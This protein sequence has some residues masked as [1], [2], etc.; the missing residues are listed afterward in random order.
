MITFKEYITEGVTLGSSELRKPNSAT[1]QPRTDILRDLINARTPLETKDGK[2]VLVTDI[3]SAMKA[4]DQFEVDNKNFNLH[5]DRGLIKNTQLKKSKAFGGGGA[6]AGGGTDQTRVT[7]SAQCLWCAALLELGPTTPME[8][9]TEEHL[10]SAQRFI[11]VDAKFDEMMNISDAWK[12]SSYLSAQKLIQEGYIKRGM[13]FHRNDRVMK[14]I[15]A[16]KD[17][18]Y[19]N[20]D[21][22]KMSDDKWNPG[23]IWALDPS[24]DVS[25][26]DTTSIRGLQKSI[27][28][29]FVNRT[30]VAISLKLV[31]KT[32]KIKYYN[33][34]LP[35]DTD[36]HKITSIGGKSMSTGRGTFWSAKG[37]EIIVDGSTKIIV[38]DN[39]S[40]GTIKAEI[41]GKTARGGGAA[42]GYL[43]TALRQ[44]FGTRLPSVRDIS[45]VA[46][47]AHAGNE[48]DLKKIYDVFSKV[49]RMTYEEFMEQ[50]SSSN[51][52]ATWLHAKYGV[53]LFLEPLMS[54]GGSKAD[55][56]ITK[57]VNYAASSSED[58]SAFIKVYT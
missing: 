58:S 10:K 23:D 53:C 42:W 43:A 57:I 24:V 52:D 18:A 13:H 55:R 19:K 2:H 20:T 54:N 15:Y 34:K 4:I 50:I 27:L 22:P 36:D 5:T 47:S 46:Q 7:E 6:G 31:K 29:H 49:E 16:A 56:A 40:F 8:N 21:L 30:M 28:D 39:A 14:S 9:V 48:R 33:I 38:R 45:N 35:P 12:E 41:M 11:H 37:G 1:K 26:L 51:I 32:A 25:K 3:D 44:V 17:K